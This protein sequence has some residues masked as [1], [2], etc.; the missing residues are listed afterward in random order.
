M[1]ALQY[2]NV[3]ANQIA[4][5]ILYLVYL[6]IGYIPPTNAGSERDFSVLARLLKPLTKGPLN[7]V[8][9]ERRTFLML[10]SHLWDVLPERKDEEFLINL[11]AECKLCDPRDFQDED[12]D[13]EDI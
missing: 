1:N 5:P 6:S 12:S 9:V 8:T 2:W 13:E 7:I 10:N 11:L 4:Y 3:K